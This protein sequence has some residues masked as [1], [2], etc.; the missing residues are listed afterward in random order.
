MNIREYIE[1]GI[2][3]LYV[4]GALPEDQMEE[5]TKRINEYPELKEEVEKIELALISFSEKAA[6]IDKFNLPSLDNSLFSNKKQSQTKQT[7]Y[8]LYRNISIAALLL[9]IPSLIF[10]AYQYLENQNSKRIISDLR[11]Q[12]SIFTDQIESLKTSS[13]IADSNIELLKQNETTRV[14]LKGTEKIESKTLAVFYNKSSGK[15]LIDRSILPEPPK[16]MAY[17]LWSI[18]SMDPLTPVSSGMLNFSEL[19]NNSLLLSS[20]DRNAIAFG[21]TLETEA[22]ADQP[23]LDQLYALGTI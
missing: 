20:V 4:T 1:S 22:G 10:N 17:Q 2:L 8:K 9:L 19:N 7:I 21:I 11:N 13:T 16:G 6:G 18:T 14:T 23:N 5:V 15:L 3:E 12:E